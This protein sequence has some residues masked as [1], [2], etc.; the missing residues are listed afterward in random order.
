VLV[1][2]FEASVAAH[3]SPA[4]AESI[5]AMFKDREALAALPVSEFAAK[6]VTA[7]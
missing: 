2:K 3:F 6:L 1:K 4:Q 5:K 7:S